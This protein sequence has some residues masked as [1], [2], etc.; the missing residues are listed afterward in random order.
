MK[1]IL[2]KS[3]NLND[4]KQLNQINEIETL[5]IQKELKIAFSLFLKQKKQ[6]YLN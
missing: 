4:F 2:Q 6:N 1:N 3:N 5:D